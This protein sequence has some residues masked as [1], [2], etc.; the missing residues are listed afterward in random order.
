MS[1]IIRS[2][3]FVSYRTREKA[4]A[5]AATLNER[6]EDG[7]SYLVKPTTYGGRYVIEIADEKGD[8][9]GLL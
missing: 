3:S 4:E 1:D 9:V 6:D 2:E 5:M 7:W 8:V